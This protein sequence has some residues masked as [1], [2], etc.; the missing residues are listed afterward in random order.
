[1]SFLDGLF[2]R[3]TPVHDGTNATY[4]LVQDFFHQQLCQFQGVYF[5]FDTV[6]VLADCCETWM[7][8]HIIMHD[9]WCISWF[10]LPKNYNDNGKT[11]PFEDVSP[12]QKC[13]FSIEMLD[14]GDVVSPRLETMSLSGFL[15][16]EK[17]GKSRWHFEGEC[18][19]TKRKERDSR[20]VVMR[21][22]D[23]LWWLLLWTIK[24]YFGPQKW[25]LRKNTKLC[26]SDLTWDFFD[27]GPC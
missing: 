22:A 11:Q 3:W 18:S 17:S 24:P 6:L 1:M 15:R 9:V 27:M 19:P 10:S 2:F 5:F 21:H 4:Q 14:F 16:Q 13:R 12:Y 7:F 25:C 8:G 20:S 26:V 23:G